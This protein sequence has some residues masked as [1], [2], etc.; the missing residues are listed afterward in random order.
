[1]KKLLLYTF[2]LLFIAV[3]DVHAQTDSSI[4]YTAGEGLS[5][6]LGKAESTKFNISGTIQSGFQ[7]SRLDSVNNT[8]LSLNLVRFA[9]N[10]SVLRDKVS[11]SLVTDFTGVSPILEGW[12][13]FPVFKKGK[14]Y[15]GQKQTHTNNRLAMADEKFAH[16]VGQTLAGRSND[17]I[18]YG[19]L[20]QNFVGAT[21]EGGV[22]AETN[23]SIG[24]KW[25]IY[26]SI[27]ITTGEGQNFFDQQG[28]TGFKYGGR[29]DVLPF[30][31]F[32]RNNAFIAEDVYREPQPKLAI[33]FAASYN[34]KASSPIGSENAT[35]GGIYNKKGITD[36][37]NYGKLVADFIF[38][39]KGFSLI[40]EYVN[41][42]VHG[43]EL[44]TNP[45]ATNQLT[46]EIA[47]K[48]YNTG[49]AYNIQTAYV[50]R[51][52]WSVG[53]RYTHIRPEFKSTTSLVQQQDW[54]T[55]SFNK[56]MMSNAVKAG[57]NVTYV[58][59]DRITDQ[60]KKWMGNLAIQISL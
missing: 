27:S 36:F 19:G 16:N 55:F 44:Y 59:E 28:N 12:I 8:R 33:G 50:T 40:G 57:L 10:A 20:M 21:R 52:G 54:F 49:S 23:F 45:G 39:S 17:G 32:T 25:K 60:S 58:K 18:V 30:G 41:G 56:F 5:I 2:P 38:K 53:G 3:V 7:Y 26:P 48:Y 47:S 46:E 6:K 9:F 34:V 11:M 43:E 35:I 31:D 37:A 1:M 14:L 15:I 4:T 13:A 51:E 22:F 24:G 42:T 29:L